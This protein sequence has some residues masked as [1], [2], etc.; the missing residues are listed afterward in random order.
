MRLSVRSL[1]ALAAALSFTATLHAQPLRITIAPGL[2]V[3]SSCVEREGSESH[4]ITDLERTTFGIEDRPLR[5]RI[6]WFMRRDPDFV[7][8]GNPT[9]IGDVYGPSGYGYRY[10][11]VTT[12]IAPYHTKVVAIRTSPMPVVTDTLVA[13]SS[14]RWSAG[15]ARELPQLDMPALTYPVGLPSMGAPDA[16]AWS[17]TRVLGD[18]EPI[19][20]PLRVALPST[21]PG[22]LVVDR[23]VMTVVIDYRV[24][25][26]GMVFA[27]YPRTAY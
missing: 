18:A 21:A 13:T 20:T 10:P 4:A 3:A 8:L 19:E 17:Y 5:Q 27:A 9:R 14:S 2:D 15:A 7:A 6:A 1:A 22:Q 25:L 11:E 23:N 16:A 26:K 24:S 12:T